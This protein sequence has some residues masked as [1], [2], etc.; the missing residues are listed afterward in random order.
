MGKQSR[1]ACVVSG[2]KARLLFAARNCRG[3]DRGVGWLRE[4]VGT[5]V[6]PGLRKR[7]TVSPQML[8]DTYAWR[9]VKRRVALE[10]ERRRVKIGRHRLRP[11]T[12]HQN[13]PYPFSRNRRRLS[14]SQVRG[15]SVT[16]T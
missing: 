6:A 3:P 2:G 1:A 16:I 4:R 5:S 8:R 14:V 7:G 9:E 11:A 12:A 10:H 13:N 15:F